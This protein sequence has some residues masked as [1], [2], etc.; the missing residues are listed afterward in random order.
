[1]KTVQLIAKEKPVVSVR[2]LLHKR[3][4]HMEPERSARILH[5]SDV[6][7]EHG[8]CPREFAL[9][10]RLKHKGKPQFVSTSMEHTFTLGRQI[11]HSLN[12]V[13]LRDVMVGD[14]RC[15]SC[16]KVKHFSKVP[17][18]HCG[19]SGV[20]CQW[21]YEEIRLKAA[22]GASGGLDGLV[23]VG[24]P[25]LRIIEVKSIDKDMYKK[26]QAPLVEHRLRT[27]MYLRMAAD[28]EE[29]IASAINTQVA[30]ILYVAK[31]FG[32]KDPTLPDHLSETFTPFKEFFIKRD[33]ESI[34]PYIARAELAHAG[35]NE[36][37]MPAGICPN[38]FNDRAKK[39]AMIAACW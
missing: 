19:Q 31:A 29:A 16:E 23:D 26:L 13:W 33:D 30:S 11:Q 9:R 4:A 25:R 17:K 8:F 21:V 6:L 38:S 24:E 32:S 36:G 15:L 37:P 10:S 5:M 18:G 35:A 12:N 27:Q 22:S 34:Q 3:L 7:K 39:C 2:E 14:W 28:S 1:M 20:R